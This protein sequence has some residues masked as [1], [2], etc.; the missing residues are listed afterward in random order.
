MEMAEILS[1]VFSQLSVVEQSKLAP[2]IDE[3]RETLAVSADAVS[4]Q[5][6]LANL[7]VRLGNLAA[8]EQAYL[9]ALIIEP[10]FVPAL[11]S[12]SDFYRRSERASE[13]KPLLE[14]ALSI[15]PDSAAA[16]HSMGLYHVRQQD[17]ASALVHLKLAIEQADAS[18]YY[19]YVYGV[20][21]ENQGQLKEAISSLKTADLRWPNQYELLMTLI[22]YLE[23]A[24][25][26]EQVLPYLS[27]LSAIAPSAPAVQ[28]LINKYRGGQ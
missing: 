16:Q 17:Y 4:T 1:D 20:A 24:G 5:L 18:P 26:T 13:E 23:Q 25:E 10:G 19:A 22:L 9:Q 15:A 6:N 2:L 11:L 12:L 14:K 8:A 28:Q 21:L 7:E 27:K 3:Y